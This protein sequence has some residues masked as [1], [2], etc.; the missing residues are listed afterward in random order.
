MDKKQIFCRG[1]GKAI[2]FVWVRQFFVA[3]E[4]EDDLLAVRLQNDSGHVLTGVCL[5]V[6]LFDAD[7]DVRRF[8][9]GGLR[10]LPGEAFILPC[11]KLPSRR[12]R[13]EVEAESFRSEDI[14]YV[15]EGNGV[16]A[17]YLPD[18]PPEPR[19]GERY[20][21]VRRSKT[22][23]LWTAAS[24]FLAALLACALCLPALL[25][26]GRQESAACPYSFAEEW[27]EV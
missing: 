25:S 27:N 21:A 7:G 23:S 11:C 22:F 24:V 6:R 8:R 19:G 20:R 17:R 12:V 26:A 3:R 5:A 18:D 15:R 9:F 16:R 1:E 4:G 13:V 2:P 10:V 14:V